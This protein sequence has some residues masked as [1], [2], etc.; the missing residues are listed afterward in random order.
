MLRSGPRCEEL[1][2]GGLTNVVR[3]EFSKTLQLVVKLT[4]QHLSQCSETV[5]L[6]CII[7]FSRFISSRYLSRYHDM[8]Y[9]GCGLLCAHRGSFSTAV[10]VG[11]LGPCMYVHYCT[12]IVHI[13]VWTL[14][15]DFI[16]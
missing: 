10:P 16:F 8:Y 4:S 11:G 5:A 1:Y 15:F 3:S 6:I 13:L 7:P 12:C 2:C 9:K 14:S